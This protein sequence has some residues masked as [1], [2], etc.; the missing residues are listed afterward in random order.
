M[1]AIIPGRLSTGVS[2]STAQ[3]AADAIN[4]LRDLVAQ[5]AGLWPFVT[6]TIASGVVA[7]WATTGET[8]TAGAAL[9]IDTEG[10]AASDDLDRIDPNGLLDTGSATA[11]RL[12][13]LRSVDAS[14]AVRLRHAQ[15]GTGQLLMPDDADWILASP[16]Q[17][18]VALW[19]PASSPRCWRMLGMLQAPVVS[20]FP[21]PLRSQTWATAGRP[22]SPEVGRRGLNTEAGCEEYWD[23]SAWRQVKDSP[24]FETTV[25]IV[26]GA[27]AYTAVAHSLG[28]M[29]SM[30]RVTLECTSADGGYVTGDE[31]DAGLARSGDGSIAVA[32]AWSASHCKIS[33]RTTPRLVRRDT[34]TSDLTV[35]AAKWR[36]RV[37]AWR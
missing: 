32:I 5:V 19:D 31:V 8:I 21:Q 27:N 15:G 20:P 17:V 16:R 2:G 11:G 22:T 14:R 18:V 28:A 9:Q 25:A 6:A 29:P 1:P 30:T 7:P 3:Q 26:D 37:R 23:G 13:V 36:W 34:P 24:Q 4:H 12:I 10:G 35:S 33:Q